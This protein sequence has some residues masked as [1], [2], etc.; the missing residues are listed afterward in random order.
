[1]RVAQVKVFEKKETGYLRE[2]YTYTN[3]VDVALNYKDNYGNDCFR[4]VYR[5][6]GKEE[7]AT[8]PKDYYGYTTLLHSEI[9]TGF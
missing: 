3:I 9:E 8:F 6:L 4:I 5:C 1:M 2:L 7:T